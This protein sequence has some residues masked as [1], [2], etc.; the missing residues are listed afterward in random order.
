MRG[1][2]VFLLLLPSVA[3]AQTDPA[4]AAIAEGLELRRQGQ[5][6][7]ALARFEEAWERSRS[8]RARAQ[9][10]L[11]EQA[12]GRWVEAEQHLREALETSDPWIAERRALL[13]QALAAI[14]THV[15]SLE[16]LTNVDGAEIFVDGALAGRTPLATI[17]VPAGTLALEVR[18]DDHVAV[19]RT[20][21]ITAGRL[22]RET[23]RLV[24]VEPAAEAPPQVDEPR[25]EE[26][27]APIEE[28]A[29]IAPASSLRDEVELG[30]ALALALA[31]S[32]ALAGFIALGVRE[33]HVQQFNS[34]ACLSATAPRRAVCSGELDAGRLAEDLAV[35][36]LVGAGVTGVAAAV[37]LGLGATMTEPS[38][39]SVACVPSFGGLLCGGRF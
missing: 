14:G 38:T 20:V 34:D 17:R 9:M 2:L 28:P 35:G 27:P 33:G 29:P 37:L 19:R 6:V 1:W 21:A 10:A 30:G 39:A 13:E 4:E 31:G 3:Y 23:V 5:D 7:A 8:P 22:V 11:A 24:A 32:S 25:V 15:G 18:A 12:L 36:F 16:V 26:L